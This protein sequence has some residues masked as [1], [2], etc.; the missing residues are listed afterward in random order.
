MYVSMDKVL[1]SIST[2]L[3]LAEIS[4]I[5]NTNIIVEDVTNI[6]YSNHLFLNHSQR[7]CYISLCLA[8]ALNIHGTHL[9]ELYVSSL[10]HDIGATNFLSKSHSSS[11]FILGHC[12]TGSQITKS[13]PI[14]NNISNF[15]LYHHENWDGSGALNMKKE[16]IPIQ[17]QIIRLS[18][19]TDLLYKDSIPSYEQKSYIINWINNNKN[20]IFCPEVVDAF[21]QV[22]CTD[23]FWLDLENTSYLKSALDNISPIHDYKL[24]LH[25]FMDIAYI[26]SE[27]I[28]NKS[29]FTAD[30]SREIAKLCYKVGKAIGY[31]ET[32]C[33]KLKIAGLL[34]DIGKLAIPKDI[35]DKKGPLT[36]KEF[37]VI[38]SHP[39]Y[40]NI[41]LNRFGEIGDIGSWASNH[42]EKLN[43]KGYPRGLKAENLCQED[44]IIAVCD[45]Y[46]ALIEDR[47]YRKGM[48]L[49]KAFS[50]LDKMVAES[51]ICGKAVY[52]LKQAMSYNN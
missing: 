11:K 50:I 41:I 30:H 2:A 38:K 14:F 12:I 24:D 23:M 1:I 10:L 39:Y 21:L 20:I 32:R 52:N 7:T 17:S 19:L 27:I 8:K 45:I 44:R 37:S 36:K 42:H 3:D 4:S 6:D 22:S 48:N 40:T 46:Q 18:D 15:I 29:S 5:G 26:F 25:K 49:K 31:D 47:P 43:G 9:E 16:N 51:L 35:L 13:F 33:M 28:D 34:H